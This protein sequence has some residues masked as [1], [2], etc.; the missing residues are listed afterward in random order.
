MVELLTQ[1]IRH[2]VDTP[3][4]VRITELSNDRA[5]LIE[6]RVAPDDVGKVIGRDGRIINALRQIIKA[7]A[8][9]RARRIQIDIVP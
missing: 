5:L 6:I 2:I 9:K 8:G 3:D 1:I 7:A 4:E